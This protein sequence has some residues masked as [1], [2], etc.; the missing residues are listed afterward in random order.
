MI[1]PMVDATGNQRGDAYFAKLSRLGVR[2]PTSK[3]SVAPRTN[4][5][6]VKKESLW[7]FGRGR[8]TNEPQH[9]VFE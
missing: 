1:R 9:V 5:V 8:N 2:V 4:T 6:P 7:T 3:Y